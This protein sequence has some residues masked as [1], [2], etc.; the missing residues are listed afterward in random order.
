MKTSRQKIKSQPQLELIL[1]RL[2]VEGKKVVFTNGCFDILHP[3]H[4]RYLE[5]ARAQGDLLVVAINSDDSVRRIKGRDRPILG[6][7]ERCEMVSALGCVDFVTTFSEET[8]QTIIEKLVP[9]ILVKGGDWPKDK[10]VG[11]EV[12]E[13]HGGKVSSIGFEKGFSTSRIIERIRRAGGQDVPP[14]R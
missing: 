7:E 13:A 6:A 14:E 10:I 8:P 4:I 1:S 5:K 12:V 9:D 2:R 11:S 3:G